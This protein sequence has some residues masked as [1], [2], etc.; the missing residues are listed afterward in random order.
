M[1]KDILEPQDTPETEPAAEAVKVTAPE[2]E[3]V[4]KAPVSRH[5]G[6]RNEIYGSFLI[7]D[8]EFAIPVSAVQE[9]INQPVSISPMPLSPSFMLGLINLR[10]KI[11]PIVDL[12]ILLEFPESERSE[13][14][15]I[16]IIEHGEH[17]IGL[18][19]DKTGEVLSGHGAARVDFRNADGGIKDLV[20]EGVLKLNNGERLVQVL[21]PYELLKLEKVP[22]SNSVYDKKAIESDRGKRRS[23]ISFQTG[24]T[25]CALD[26]RF[27]K[28]VRVM[29]DVDQ[30]I[31]ANGNVIGTTNLRGVILP[32]V[33]F[34]G[35]MGDTAKF[36]LGRTE[37][38]ERRLLII[39]TSEGPI[40]LMV[41]SID[42]ILTYFENE[43]LPFARLALARSDFVSGCIMDKQS[44]IIMMLD[45]EALM[46]EPGLVSIAK[47]CQEI[48]CPAEETTEEKTVESS[49]TRRT[50]I[51]FTF[52]NSFALDTSMVSEVINRPKEILEPPY[53]LSFVE[54]IINLRGELFT[55]INPRLLYGL[56]P[57]TCTDQKVLVF[58]HNQQK[59]GILV[60]SV[61]EIIMTTESSV[62]EVQALNSHNTSRRV[63][64]DVSGC[65]QHTTSDGS[66]NS[67]LIMDASALIERCVKSVDL[68]QPH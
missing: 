49:Q 12:R 28:E 57:K 47:S 27:V 6:K 35:F 37:P 55:L 39:E 11:V 62:S 41:F 21:N 2:Q 14:C 29:P 23:C 25:T 31:F 4:A 33:D 15:K 59:Y 44:K 36:N 5:G 18:R 42:S 3:P 20:I 30:S 24:H 7:D 66:L 46:T 32:V 8:S 40:G 17:C 64:E 51:R 13:D 26:L 19:V 34:R 56:P 67:I 45:H 50:F 63:A 61:D 22:R 43:V 65:L 48:Y 9:V 58:K 68:G 16:A 1:S 10:G 38:K 54:G 52:E 60:D 53:S